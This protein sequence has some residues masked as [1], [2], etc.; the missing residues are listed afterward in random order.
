M[1]DITI[2]TPVKNNAETIGHNLR[3]IAHQGVSSQHILI[4]GGSTDGTLE[5]IQ[6]Q[7]SSGSIL[8]SEPDQGMYDAINKGLKL[9][10]G[11]IVGIL[12]G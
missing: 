1:T 8:I 5:I 12:S 3:S 4:D 10:T 2:I 6:R 7:P 9:A 11:D